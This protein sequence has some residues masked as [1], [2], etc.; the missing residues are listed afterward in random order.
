MKATHKKELCDLNVLNKKKTQAKNP[1]HLNCVLDLL[2]CGMASLVLASLSLSADLN[3]GMV[4]EPDRSCESEFLRTKVPDL[5]RTYL[6]ESLKLE[7]R[8][9]ATPVSYT[10]LTLPTIYSV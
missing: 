6:S 3:S 1:R 4:P 9:F 7:V 2:P 10:H 8:D 5:L